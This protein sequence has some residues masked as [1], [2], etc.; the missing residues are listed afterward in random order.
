MEETPFSLG[1]AANLRASRNV[2]FLKKPVQNWNFPK[3]SSQTY[4][5]LQFVLLL[6]ETLTLNAQPKQM[7]FNDLEKQATKEKGRKEEEMIYI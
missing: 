5:Q 2:V 4:F 7:H 1:Q 3:S 6:L